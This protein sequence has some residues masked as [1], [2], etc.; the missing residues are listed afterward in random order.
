[1]KVSVSWFIINDIT[2]N[3]VMV[4]IWF[5]NVFINMSF[6]QLCNIWFYFQIKFYG[7]GSKVSKNE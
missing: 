6:M 2:P 1:M 4:F 7:R 3:M 5:K